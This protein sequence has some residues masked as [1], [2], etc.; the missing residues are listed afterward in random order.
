M[1]MSECVNAAAERRDALSCRTSL[2]GL[3]SP[4]H[5]PA[6]ASSR[7][8]RRQERILLESGAGGL[9]GAFSG[10]GAAAELAACL[11]PHRGHT[12][13]GRRRADMRDSPR[14]R[15]QRRAFRRTMAG[16]DPE[17]VVAIAE[18]GANT[19]MTPTDGR[20]RRGQRVK[21]RVPGRW[22]SVTLVA[23]L[24][25]SG[26]VAPMAFARAMDTAH[27]RAYVEPIL[28]PRLHSGDVVVWDNLK[29]H[30]ATHARQA[31]EAE[32]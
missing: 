24:R 4:L 1:V 32:G 8:V 26:V 30:Q 25:L 22:E 12:S 11:E 21:G 17:H 23:G 27:F 15:R 13:C 28:K 14:V 19:A 29:P 20:A 31:V 5:A 2:A 16:I 7:L 9:L 3:S 18:T 6:T 10:R